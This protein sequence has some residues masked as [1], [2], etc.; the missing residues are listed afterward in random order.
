MCLRIITRR[1]SVMASLESYFAPP[2]EVMGMKSLNKEAFKRDITLPAIKVPAKLCSRMVE[3]LKDVTLKYKNTIKRVQDIPGGASNEVKVLLLIPEP[4]RDK[5]LTDGDLHWIEEHDGEMTSHTITLDYNHYSMH[6]ILR[7][8]LPPE[9]TDVPSAFE[10]V[11]HIA[12]LNLRENHLPYKEII[13]QVLLDKHAHIQTVVNKSSSI[14][15]TFRF[16]KM[17]LL[18]GEDRM[19]A[20]VRENDC[21]FTLDFSKVYWNSRLHTEHARVIKELKRTDTVLDMF[22]G[23]GP[24]AI[25][26][27]KKGCLVYANDLNPHAYQ[28]LY[29][30]AERNKVSQRMRCFN[31][32]GREFVKKVIGQMIAD[33]PVG[34]PFPSTHIIMNLPASAVEFLD[35]FRGMLVGIEADK[36][37]TPLPMLHC[38][39]FTKSSTPKEDCVEQVERML[40]GKLETFDIFEVR[41]VSP[42]KLMMRVRFALPSDVAYGLGGGDSDEGTPLPKKPCLDEDRLCE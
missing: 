6:S 9:V 26:A 34:H 17:D 24:F 4:F 37:N 36:D 11:G 20:T 41:D 7:A 21:S 1:L 42:N 27:C 28:A 25:P 2:P 12:H 5:P 18:A 39:C 29:K 19:V 23:V 8:V 40:R 10:S 32:D 14:D 35:V 22:A 3:R 13:G 38:Y 30:N 33:R 31:L 15:E 16:L